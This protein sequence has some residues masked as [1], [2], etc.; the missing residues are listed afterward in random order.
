VHRALPEPPDEI[1]EPDPGHAKALN[2]IAFECSRRA[3]EASDAGD[4]AA[5]T[6]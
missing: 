5:E 3:P 6:L 1:L 2:L 4:I